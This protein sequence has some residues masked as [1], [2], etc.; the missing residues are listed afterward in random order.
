MILILLKNTS[1]NILSKRDA[2]QSKENL[3]YLNKIDNTSALWL[4]D[5]RKVITVNSGKVKRNTS[6]RKV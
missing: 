3:L 2:Q 4:C 5:H 6:L 1:L